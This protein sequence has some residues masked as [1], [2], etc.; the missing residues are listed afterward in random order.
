MK[1]NKIKTENTR[2][3]AGIFPT[4][5]LN[6]A[7]RAAAFSPNQIAAVS[8]GNVHSEHRRK[9]QR[10]VD[11]KVLLEAVS[12]KGRSAPIHTSDN[13]KRAE[14]WGQRRFGNAGREVLYVQI[15]LTQAYKV[16]G[17]SNVQF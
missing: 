4:V 17:R 14:T 3:D 1:V 9:G 16:G 5:Q 11:S 6:L 13:R 10:E 15:R 8:T 7:E 12:R 2:L